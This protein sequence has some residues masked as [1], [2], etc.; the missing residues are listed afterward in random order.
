MCSLHIVPIQNV[1]RWQRWKMY[2]RVLEGNVCSN[3]STESNT[4]L[5]MEAFLQQYVHFRPPELEWVCNT[6]LWNWNECAVQSS[7][8]LCVK[9]HWIWNV[10]ST[11][12]IGFE[13]CAVQSTG[14]GM[15]AVYIRFGII[16]NVCN[17]ERWNRNVCSDQSTGTGMC[18]I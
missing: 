3:A 1:C 14:V 7:V 9:Q 10:C 16:W 8:F 18:A 2:T 15:C 17:T 6:E 5:Q 13:R 4:D 12:S 11:I